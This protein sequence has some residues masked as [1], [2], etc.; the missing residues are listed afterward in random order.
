MATTRLK[1]YNGALLICGQ[2]QL[3]SLTEN[4]EARHLLDNVWN[5]SG[6]DYCLSQGQW[7]FAIRAQMLDYS[8][9]ITP[10]FGLRRAFE[11]STDWILT[12]AVCQ[13]EYFNTPLLQYTDEAGVLYSDLD[14]IYVKFV[15]NDTGYGGN[16]ALWPP[17]FTEYVKH[18]FAG[19][20][21]D[22]VSADQTRRA[23]LLT[24]RTG[25]LDQSLENARNRDAIS[26]PTRFLPK[27]SWVRARGGGRSGPRSDGGN[28][29]SLIG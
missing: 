26:E 7:R 14:Q 20:I 9:S 15:S 16:L 10:D 4:A 12:S 19:K 3:A 5:D 28:F 17:S 23:A 27:G 25:L 21:I 6:I 13:D 18:Y 2:R 24:R 1:L 22:K 8:T 29:N 11:K